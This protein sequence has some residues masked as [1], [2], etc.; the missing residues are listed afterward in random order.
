M[1][2][3]SHL[4]HTR[5]QNAGVGGLDLG[6]RSGAT[7][8]AIARAV[9]APSDT[10]RVWCEGFDQEGWVDAGVGG[11]DSYLWPHVGHLRGGVSS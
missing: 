3:G 9:R 7:L 10:I 1:P 11:L 6:S 5:S 2:S 4:V 8:G